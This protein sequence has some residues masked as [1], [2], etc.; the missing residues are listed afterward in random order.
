MVDKNIRVLIIE[1]AHQQALVIEKMLNLMGYYCVAATAT[2]EEGLLLNR[3]G[4][5]NFDV[6]IAPFPVLV[7]EHCRVTRFKGFNIRNLFLYSCSP[8]DHDIPILVKGHACFR[9]GLPEYDAL[10]AF[11]VSFQRHSAASTVHG[12]N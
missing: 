7:L 11:M 12:S 2:V 5:R 1:P 6:L 3:Y 9:S 4:L 8:H 10:Q